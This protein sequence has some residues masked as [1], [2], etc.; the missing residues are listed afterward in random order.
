MNWS[1]YGSQQRIGKKWSS[2]FSPKITTAYHIT[3]QKQTSLTFLLSLSRAERSSQKSQTS[4]QSGKIRQLKNSS[5]SHNS[6]S[7]KNPFHHLSAEP[8]HQQ[9]VLQQYSTIITNTGRFSLRKK[10]KISKQ[11]ERPP[12][13]TLQPGS[14]WQSP[15][16]M[17]V[18]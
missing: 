7:L 13:W 1:E 8:F 2:Q 9:K 16:A 5:K 3:I 6:V 4:Q 11:N 10:K 18:D 17:D 14:W 12:L 15:P